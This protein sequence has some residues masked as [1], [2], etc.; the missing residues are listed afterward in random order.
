MKYILSLVLIYYSLVSMSQDSMDHNEV[1]EE[2]GRNSLKLFTGYTLVPKGNRLEIGKNLIV[3]TIGIDYAFFLKPKLYVGLYADLELS[4]YLVET[5][6][7]SEIRRKNA[8]SLA[9]VIG[10]EVTNWLILFAGGGIEIE[11]SRN[12]PIIKFGV[13]FT[14][15]IGE[16][17]EISI[18]VYWDYKDEY[19]ALGFGLGVSKR[20]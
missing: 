11:K 6:D 17:W 13:E 20:F 3:P 7:G 2:Y 9:T 5:G 8:F 15:R 12:L 16:G 19:T 1:Q 14:K 10:R 18:P 4:N